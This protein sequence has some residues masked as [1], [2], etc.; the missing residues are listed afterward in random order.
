MKVGVHPIVCKAVM[1]LKAPRGSDAA[2]CSQFE[3][4]NSRSEG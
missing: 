2:S 4:E 1:L 3:E